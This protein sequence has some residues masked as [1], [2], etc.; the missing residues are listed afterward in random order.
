MELGIPLIIVNGIEDG[1]V[2][3]VDAGVHG[4]EDDG[5]EA[6]RRVLADI[7]PATLR[8]TLVGIPA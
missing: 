6:I 1:P 5:Q 3:C 2:L 7:D 8:G 4:D